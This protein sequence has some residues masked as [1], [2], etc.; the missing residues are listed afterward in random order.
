[1]AREVSLERLARLS[2]LLG[3]VG[4]LVGA[5]LASIVPQRPDGDVTA[6][7]RFD[8]QYDRAALHQI[9]HAFW[10]NLSGALV[11]WGLLE[12]LIRT[13]CSR[14]TFPKGRSRWYVL[15]F[16]FHERRWAHPLLL[17]GLLIVWSGWAW[18]QSRGWQGELFLEPGVQS[19]LGVDQNPRLTFGRFLVPPAPDG[20]GRALALRLI[21]DGQ[22]HDIAEVSPYRSDGWIL[23]P[24]WYGVTVESKELTKP[25]F[26]GGTGTQ[27]AALRSG[28]RV[29]VSLDAETLE[30]HTLP[31]LS[32]LEAHYHAILSARFAPG[33]RLILPG[34]GMTAAGALLS[35]PSARYNIRKGREGEEA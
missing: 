5:L 13:T 20:P 32:D 23:Q 12:R 22:A 21:V 2:L 34:L 3:I 27:T 15:R 14:T 28:E 4:L 19:A 1:M 7:A 16:T 29:S 26:F 30:A 25:L 33:D 10:W 6:L 9:H 11:A 8:A 18:N 35:L 24:Q 31:P 17:A